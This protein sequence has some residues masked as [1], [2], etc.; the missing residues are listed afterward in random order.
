M[1]TR[2][3]ILFLMSDEHRPDVTGYEGNE[4]VR[5]PVL[6]ELAR[7]GVVFRNAYTPSP[8]CVPGRQCLM[9]GQL[10]KTCGYEGW[11]DL[12]PGHMTFAR[13]FACHA[14][15][16]VCC[17]KLHHQTYDQ[18]QGWMSRPAGDIS[19]STGHL[20]GRFKEEFKRYERPFADYK[21]SDAKEVKRAGVGRSQ[22][23]V[24]DEDWTD[25]AL[26]S[27][28]RHFNSAQ[29]DPSAPCY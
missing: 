23:V 21:W 10:P 9:S 19:M 8:I 7:T 29:Y 11:F 2:P 6:D 5:T 18:M 4:V 12:K 26:K 1:S 3:N 13:Q 27:I 25:A 20:E 28:E 14:Y 24:N 16:T 17:G 22:I 15:A